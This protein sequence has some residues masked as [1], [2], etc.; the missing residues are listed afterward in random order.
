MFLLA[1]FRRV[2]RR[3]CAAQP[4]PHFPV[5]LSRT[6]RLVDGENLVFLLVRQAEQPLDMLE[7][8]QVFPL[9]KEYLAIR[10]VDNGFLYDR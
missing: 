9:V 4:D 6:V 1:Y 7:L 8:V 3:L 2:Y 5:D 10:V